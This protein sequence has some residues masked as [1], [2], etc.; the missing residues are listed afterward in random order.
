M[1]VTSTYKYFVGDTTSTPSSD[2]N[3]D[4]RTDFVNQ[5]N[6]DPDEIFDFD[7]ILAQTYTGISPENQ[8]VIDQTIL[9]PEAEV[10]GYASSGASKDDLQKTLDKL[11]RK[12]RRKGAGQ[13]FLAGLGQGLNLNLG[14][15]PQAVSQPIAQTQATTNYEPQNAGFSFQKE[16]GNWQLYLLLG[17]VGLS[18]I[19]FGINTKKSKSAA[20]DEFIDSTAELRTK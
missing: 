14:S 5:V 3:L 7:N 15:S 20:K 12:E 2:L 13:G 1:K 16:Q 19:I 6:Y 11:K 18:L 10:V 17:L 8:V 9:L 4:R